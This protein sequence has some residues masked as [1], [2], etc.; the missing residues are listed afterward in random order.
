M[1]RDSSL[2]WLQLKYFCKFYK[3]IW[4]YEHI[5]WALHVW[6]GLCQ[7]WSLKLKFMVNLPLLMMP[8]QF[9]LP[10][11]H[12][13]ESKFFS[14]ADWALS[15]THLLLQIHTPTQTSH[16]A[17][18]QLGALHTLFSLPGIPF[19]AFFSWEHLPL[20]QEQIECHFLCETIPD[21]T[22]D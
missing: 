2:N 21:S 3:N 13:I 1:K 12:Q 4:P 18:W 15:W 14:W 10:V 19:I 5:A 6:K 11:T 20:L 16:H 22:G 9:R 17:G 8:L 7:T